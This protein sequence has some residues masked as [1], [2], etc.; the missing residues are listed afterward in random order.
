MPGISGVETL[1]QL[2]RVCPDTPV[3][4]ITAFYQSYFEPLKQLETEG[5]DFQLARKP[6][7]SNDI[8]EIARGVLEGPEA[9]PH[10]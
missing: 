8:R 7:A 10:V 2:R 3:Y 9:R 1:R 6:L 5:V 4:I